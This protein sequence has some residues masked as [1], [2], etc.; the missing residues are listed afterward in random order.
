[1]LLAVVRR[2]LVN[3]AH[4]APAPA[5]LHGLQGAPSISR[6]QCRADRPLVVVEHGRGIVC[7]RR[8]TS[9]R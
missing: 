4:A 6:R 3:R 9:W 8:Q 2:Q 7:V 5:C 1:M